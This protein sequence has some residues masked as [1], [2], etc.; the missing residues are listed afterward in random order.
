MKLSCK[1]FGHDWKIKERSNVIQFDNMGYP[2][3]LF[4]VECSKCKQSRQEWIDSG[5][6]SKDV[7][8]EWKKDDALPIPPK[9][10]EKLKCPK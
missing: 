2:L 9:A 1:I 5:K 3:R 7:V 4:I 6:S 10:E 8:C